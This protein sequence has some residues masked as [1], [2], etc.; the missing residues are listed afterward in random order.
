[1]IIIW[2]PP[3]QTKR[4]RSVIRN[5]GPIAPASA[6]GLFERPNN[7]AMDTS[8]SHQLFRKGVC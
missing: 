8:A 4:Q 5:P 3:D 1:M 2:K 7:C 6:A